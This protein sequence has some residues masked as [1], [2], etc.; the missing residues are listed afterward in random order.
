LGARYADRP[1]GYTRIIRLGRRDGDNAELAIIELVG[2]PREEEG[3]D[4]KKAKSA[5]TGR[6]KT[7]KSASVKAE[8]TGAG[9]TKKEGRGGSRSKK[10]ESTA[11]EKG[12]D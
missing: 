8:A 11:A 12:T 6:K 4:S 3:T 2:N 1:G 5:T 7:T 10:K 9:T